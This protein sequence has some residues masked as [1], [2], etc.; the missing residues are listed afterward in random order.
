MAGSPVAHAATCTLVKIEE[1]PVNVVRNHL[2][3]D[4][5]VNGQNVGIMIDTGA[6]RSLVLRSAADRLGLAR[7]EARNLRMYGIGGETRVEIARVESFSIGNTTRK[8]WQLIVA[9]E[10]EFGPGIDVI[11]GDDFFH[12]TD[13][14]FDLAH[15]AVRLFQARDCN[16]T[17]LAYW[18]KEVAGEVEIESVLDARPQIIIEVKINGRPVRAL[19]DSGAAFSILP[20]ADAASAGVTP[21]TPGVVKVDAGTGLGRNTFDIWIGPFRS[22]SIG[23][24]TIRDTAIRFGDLYKGLTYTQTGTLVVRKVGDFQPM[25]LGA[26]FLRAHRVLVAHSQRK[27]YFTYLGGPVF[28]PNGPAVPRSEPRPEGNTTTTPGTN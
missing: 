25:L 7:K 19:L 3:V 14:E 16:G 22:F 20:I 26:D 11:L 1:W 4:G 24:E 8:D 6:T 18:T 13:V 17:S 23:N 27:L 9:G 10:R 21:E 2:I 15:R 5:A 28:Q 12:S